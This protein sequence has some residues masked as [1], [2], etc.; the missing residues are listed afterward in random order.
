MIK[1]CTEPNTDWLALRAALWPSQDKQAHWAEMEQLC[2]QPGRYA[3]LLAY[4][5]EG[6]VQGFVEIAVRS[7]YVNGTESSPVGFLEGIY[8]LDAFRGRGIARAL[9]ARA[10]E[11]L[12]GQGIAEF[13]SDALLD[14]ATSHA[15]HRSLGFEETERV[16]YFRKRLPQPGNI[17][18]TNG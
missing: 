15:M 1:P 14:N 9:V 5:H 13:A 2:A 8:V 17:A 11:W 7:D 18:S 6:T 16:V 3:Q 10:E 4:G 12:L